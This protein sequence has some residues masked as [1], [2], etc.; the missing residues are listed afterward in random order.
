MRRPFSAELWVITQ[1]LFLARAVTWF[2]MTLS[3]ILTPVSWRQKQ[4][5]TLPNITH[6]TKEN[7]HGIFFHFSIYVG[8]VYT[9]LQIGPQKRE[10]VNSRRLRD[11]CSTHTTSLEA[12]EFHYNSKQSHMLAKELIQ[13]LQGKI[14]QWWG[15]PIS[16]RNF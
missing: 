15:K 12:A 14:C 8:I 4:S 7:W 2:L 16:Y 13:K 9:E 11:L 5:V 3:R 1:I 10:S 6:H